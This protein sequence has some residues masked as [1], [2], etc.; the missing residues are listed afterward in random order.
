MNCLACLSCCPLN[1]YENIKSK[2]NSFQNLPN[3]MECS[4]IRIIS[5][6]NILI[7]YHN[8]SSNKSE[9]YN[10]KLNNVKIMQNKN[11]EA[12]RALISFILNKHIIINNITFSTQIENQIH[13]DVIY[14]NI[15][16]NSWLIYNNLAS[17]D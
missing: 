7:S 16:V 8:E 2:N 3:I 4:V 6:N 14:E 17:Y 11:A 5:S 9:Y 13:G 10:V 15:N 1:N 12:I